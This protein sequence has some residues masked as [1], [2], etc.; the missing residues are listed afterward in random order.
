[1]SERPKLEVAIWGISINAEGIAAIA[2]AFLIVM[3]ILAL[4]R[5]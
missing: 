2:A 1:M 3:V 4:Y 5:F